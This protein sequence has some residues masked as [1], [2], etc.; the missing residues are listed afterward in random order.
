M[1]QKIHMVLSNPNVIK[2]P[3]IIPRPEKRNNNLKS[4]FVQRIHNVKPGCGS[5]GK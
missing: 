5:C 2:M 3:P 1:P 4:P